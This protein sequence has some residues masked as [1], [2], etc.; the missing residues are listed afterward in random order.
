[1]QSL[2]PHSYVR[3]HDPAASQAAGSHG[4][5]GRVPQLTVRLQ[6]RGPAVTSK[7][8]AEYLVSREDPGIRPVATVL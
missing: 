4:V 2:M 1:M 6:F 5:G 8:G 3:S 7:T